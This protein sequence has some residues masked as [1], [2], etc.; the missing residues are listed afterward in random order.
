MRVMLSYIELYQTLTGFVLYKLYNSVGLLYPPPDDISII[1]AKSLP[2]SG[3][4]IDHQ[5]GRIGSVRSLFEGCKIFLSREVPRTSLEFVITCFGG[6]VSWEGD[7]APFPVTLHSIT[8]QI[9]DRSIQQGEYI[10]RDYVQPQWVYDCVNE[11]LL[12]PVSDYL[13]TATLP[14]HLSPFV[15]YTED[16]Y[17]PARHTSLV[18]LKQQTLQGGAAASDNTASVTKKQLLQANQLDEEAQFSVDLAAE[19][20]G[21]TSTTIQKLTQEQDVE[22]LLPDI[23]LTKKHKQIFHKAQYESKKQRAEKQRLLLRRPQK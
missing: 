5:D 23:M 4:F 7:D 19:L 15:E 16:S 20:A 2:T 8:H 21:Q 12:L 11:Q 3:N 22:R 14:P 6:E 10:S 17:V 9:V 1:A 18:E 13:P